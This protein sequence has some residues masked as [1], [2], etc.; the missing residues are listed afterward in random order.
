VRKFGGGTIPRTGELA[1]VT[2][3]E[4]GPSSVPMVADFRDHLALAFKPAG[5]LVGIDMH[6]DMRLGSRKPRMRDG[7]WYTS[8]DMSACERWKDVILSGK[9]LDL[10]PIS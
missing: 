5:L 10:W 2:V 1:V 8:L 7:V 6:G 3:K 9:D 4:I